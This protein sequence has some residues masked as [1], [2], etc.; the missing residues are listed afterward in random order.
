MLY[1]GGDINLVSE[2]NCKLQSSDK[3][4]TPY[5]KANDAKDANLLRRS[6]H[7]NLYAIVNSNIMK[8]EI[9]GY[10]LPIWEVGLY[11]ADGAIAGVLV[12]WGA[13]V[14]VT[15]LLAKPKKKKGDDAEEVP[16]EPA[17]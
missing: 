6:A 8:A 2:A 1:A 14:I 17:N 15:A 9:L 13:A 5:V 11:A 12:I 10:K 3:Y 4:G 16:A 7:N